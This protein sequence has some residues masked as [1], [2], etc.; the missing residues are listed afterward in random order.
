MSQ[1]MFRGVDKGPHILRTGSVVRRKQPAS[2]RSR[3]GADGPGYFAVGFLFA[4]GVVVLAPS[5]KV[6]MLRFGA[7]AEVEQAPGPHAAATAAQSAG[8][9]RQ[10]RIVATPPA[11]LGRAGL[12]GGGSAVA[13]REARVAAAPPR[14]PE[15][16]SALASD[17]KSLPSGD[18]GLG[19]RDTA[20][21]RD[22]GGAGC[23]SYLATQ[24]VPHLPNEL[25]ARCRGERR[26]VLRRGGPRR[27]AAGPPG[28]G[29]GPLLR[30]Q[31]GRAAR[32]APVRAE[33]A[34]W[35]PPCGVGPSLPPAA[36]CA[37]VRP[38]K[39]LHFGNKCGCF[40]WSRQLICVHA[41]RGSCV[42]VDL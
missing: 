27:R 1:A 42:R 35:P 26:G 37:R 41:P 12:T 19:C 18:L 3:V 16:V 38:E 10:P 30:R 32:R 34:L 14:R 2:M 31:Q 17:S 20:G 28:R 6:R 4:I 22:E 15:Q 33:L 13:D 8:R 21:W 29:W 11:G 5:P 9:Q 39:E 24:R 23:P 25:A 40:S 36:R 7:R